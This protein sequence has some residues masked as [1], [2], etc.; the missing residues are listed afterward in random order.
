[1]KL[2]DTSSW[3]E[4]LRRGGDPA[5]RERVEALLLTG[6]AAWCPMVRLELWNGAQGE[7]ERAVLREM[8]REVAALEIGEEVWDLAAGLARGA[9]QKGV[10]V[11]ATDLLVAACAY[12]HGLGIE[13]NDS[14]FGLIATLAPR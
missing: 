5:V 8:E 6:E 13:H 1:M 4:Q 9:R 3:I 2:V 12:H 7:R 14:H 11:P 10:T